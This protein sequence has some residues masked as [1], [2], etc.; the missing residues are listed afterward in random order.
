MHD[1]AQVAPPAAGNVLLEYET[2]TVNKLTLRGTRGWQKTDARVIQVCGR[3]DP[4][5]GRKT[6]SA[7]RRWRAMEAGRGPSSTRLAAR[8]RRSA[9]TREPADMTTRRNGRKNACGP[10][11]TPSS[12]WVPANIGALLIRW[13]RW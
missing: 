3:P 2:G 8:A 4:M 5:R 9:G 12:N 13:R 10:V 1:S 7:T 6:L 11:N